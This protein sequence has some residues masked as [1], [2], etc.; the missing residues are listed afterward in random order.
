MK[1]V[2]GIDV[3]ASAEKLKK[4]LEYRM[5]TPPPK[6]RG[7]AESIDGTESAATDQSPSWHSTDD[8]EEDELRARINKGSQASKHTLV[9]Y[10][11]LS[12]RQVKVLRAMG[13]TISDCDVKVLVEKAH[14]LARMDVLE[15]SP[16]K[17]DQL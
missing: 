3:G 17:Q 7:R 4:P 12:S 16:A 9:E 14:V 5:Y 8:Q 15:H 6:G 10:V 11:Q 1:Q 13:S 2:H